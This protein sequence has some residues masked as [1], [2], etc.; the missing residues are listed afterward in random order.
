ME[1]HNASKIAQLIK[2][3]EFH[4]ERLSEYQKIYNYNYWDE[5][6]ICFNN[7]VETT[8]LPLKQEEIDCLINFTKNKV[9]QIEN[10]IKTF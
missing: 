9:S 1:L 8:H 7:F 4:K 6:H 2:E 10:E 3:L 5:L